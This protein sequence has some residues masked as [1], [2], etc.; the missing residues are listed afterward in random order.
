MYN[1]ATGFLKDKDFAAIYLRR[2]LE[3]LQRDIFMR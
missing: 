1:Q 3:G 2:S